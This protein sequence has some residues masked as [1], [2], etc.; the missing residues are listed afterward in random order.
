CKEF[1]KNLTVSIT[2]RKEVA[3]SSVRGVRIEF[4]GMILGGIL[5]IPGK[6][7]ICE[8]IK[9]L[10]TIDG[11]WWH[12]TGENKRRDDEDETPIENVQNEGVANEG[13]NNQ[14]DFE[15]KAVNDE[16]EI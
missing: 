1:Y 6:N 9:E 12:G 14:E 11:V 4:D 15:W 7:G 16:A 10:R 5:G 8:Y 2:K 3:R 13:Q